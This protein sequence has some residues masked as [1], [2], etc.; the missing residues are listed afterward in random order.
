VADHRDAGQPA[1]GREKGACK[2]QIAKC[3][4]EI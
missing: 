3:K 4:F 2:L 1:V